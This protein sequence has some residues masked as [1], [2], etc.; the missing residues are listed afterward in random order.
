MDTVVSRDLVRQPEQRFAILS[1][2]VALQLAGGTLAASL[3]IATIM[4]VAPANRPL[5]LL[6]AIIALKYVLNSSQPIES[7]FEAQITSKYSVLSDNLA[8]VIITLL[9]CLLIVIKAPV[10]AFA[11]TISLEAL[12]Y[13]IGLVSYY[14]RFYPPGWRWQLTMS[15]ITYLLRESWPLALSSTAAVIYTNIDRV[16]LGQMLGDEAVGLYSS[17]AN[18]SDAWW[19]LPT[20]VASSLYP[21][22]I[23]AKNCDRQVYRQQ[24]QW[25]YDL[26]SALAYGLIALVMPLSGL[27]ITLLYTETYRSAAP[28]LAVYIWSTLF[29]FLGIAQSRWLVSEGLQTYALQSRLAGLVL[30]VLLNLVLIPLYQ[31]MGAAI[32]TLISYA[33]GNHLYFFLI[34]A[35][36]DQAWLMARSWA[37]PLRFPGVIRSFMRE[38]I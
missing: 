38:R 32:A 26:N 7:W 8:F 25:F 20:I 34:P 37:I 10:Y 5:Q 14:Q 9:R 1:N 15:Q 23:Q 30:N 27:I 28:V 21:T 6:V 29:V 11:I 3:A 17:A 33:V 4:L 13:A 31:G 16:M 12:I 35:T 18:L 24:M 36:R 22:I 2:A 19:F